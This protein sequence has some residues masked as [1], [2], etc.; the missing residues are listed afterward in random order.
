MYFLILIWAFYMVW[1]L[2]AIISPNSFHDMS[3]NTLNKQILPSDSKLNIVYFNKKAFPKLKCIAIQTVVFFFSNIV[4]TA[5]A[6]VLLCCLDI[7][8]IIEYISLAY[9]LLFILVTGLTI[10]ILNVKK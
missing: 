10:I 7:N 8:R 3:E 4:Y 6:T 2:F 9:L 5:V 1:Y